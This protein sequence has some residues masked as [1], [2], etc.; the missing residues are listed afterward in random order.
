MRAAKDSLREYNE[1]GE[2]DRRLHYR[3]VEIKD[4]QFYNKT[5]LLWNDPAKLEPKRHARYTVQNIDLE[6]TFKKTVR[7][8]PKIL[9]EE[10]K[11]EFKDKMQSVL[12]NKTE[13][14]ER[15]LARKLER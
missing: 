14:Q 5:Q 4:H 13:Q 2:E 15:Y 11:E 12:K 6:T 1:L 7:D 3:N 8:L 10:R 9:D